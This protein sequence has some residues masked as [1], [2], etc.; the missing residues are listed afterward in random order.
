MVRMLPRSFCK[1]QVRDDEDT[2]D[3]V[4]ALSVSCAIGVQKTRLDVPAADDLITDGAICIVM[5]L[6]QQLVDEKDEGG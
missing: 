3:K 4:D 2:D 5:Q 6:R 1:P